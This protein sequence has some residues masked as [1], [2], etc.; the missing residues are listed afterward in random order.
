[1]AGIERLVHEGS[2]EEL[3]VADASL[4]VLVSLDV[5]SHSAV[6][7][8]EG[9][10]AEFHRVL[11]RDGLVVIQLAAY[12]W[13]RSAHDI[14]AATGHRYRAREVKQLLEGAGFRDVRVSYRMSLL[15]PIA[16]AIRLL[17]RKGTE[18]DVR[19][20]PPW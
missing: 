17:R 13:L 10:A 18:T 12:E 11:R 2:V 14:A 9:A 3:P 20:V 8:D 4:D 19:P 6:G 1:P 15:F 7:S 16:A 5:L